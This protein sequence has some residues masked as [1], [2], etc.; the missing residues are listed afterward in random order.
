MKKL[1]YTI[2][3]QLIYITINILITCMY[4]LSIDDWINVKYRIVEYRFFVLICNS[5]IQSLLRKPFAANS[6][7]FVCSVTWPC[8]K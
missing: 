7:Y 1:D 4:I 2:T 3:L 8:D 5:V 6:T